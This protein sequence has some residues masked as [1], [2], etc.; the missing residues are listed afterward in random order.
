MTTNVK[1]K[2]SPRELLFGKSSL[3]QTHFLDTLKVEKYHPRIKNDIKQIEDLTNEIKEFVTIAKSYSDEERLN[4]I[5]EQNKTRME[6][7]IK[8]NSIVL[9]KN[10]N[11]V[12]GVNSAFHSYYQYC[13]YIVK[14]VATST[15][16][17]ARIGLEV[18]SREF[19][20]DIEKVPK[21]DYRL[22]ID[23]L[24]AYK[25]LHDHFKQL[26]DKVIRLLHKEVDEITSDDLQELLRNKESYK[27]DNQFY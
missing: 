2:F 1:L 27:L 6:N 7:K 18:Y 25:P 4:R 17:V 16:I 15:C 9:V 13:P 24:K 11:K 19:L 5:T 20:T 26:P 21:M 12:L 8:V 22:P 3:P 10:H 14:Q 23:H